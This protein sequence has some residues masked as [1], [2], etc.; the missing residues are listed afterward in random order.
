MKIYLA[1]LKMRVNIK[2]NVEVKNNLES[3]FRLNLNKIERELLIG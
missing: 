3:Y 2:Y 1:D